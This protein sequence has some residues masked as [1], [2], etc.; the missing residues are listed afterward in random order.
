M[1]KEKTIV[2]FRKWKD[3]GD[4]IALFPGIQSEPMHA[5]NCQSYMHVGQHGAADYYEVMRATKPIR[6]DPKAIADM[7][8]LHEELTSLGYNLEVRQRGASHLF[9]R[10]R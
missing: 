9:Y 1:D 4:V 6:L 5:Y 8:D 2:V 7:Q 3:T 10:N